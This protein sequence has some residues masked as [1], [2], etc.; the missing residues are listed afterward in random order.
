[1]ARLRLKPADS[2]EEESAATRLADTRAI[3]LLEALG[4]VEA[5]AFLKELAGGD[6]SARLTREARRA[7]KWKTGDR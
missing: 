2:A 6:D 4:T 5:R 7:L 3:E 1:M